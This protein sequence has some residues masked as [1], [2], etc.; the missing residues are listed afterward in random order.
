VEGACPTPSGIVVSGLSGSTANM[1][2]VRNSTGTEASA[3]SHHIAHTPPRT[4]GR[5]P[6]PVRSFP[7]TR[8]PPRYRTRCAMFTA[9]SSNFGFMGGG[10]SNEAVLIVPRYEVRV[11]VPHPNHTATKPLRFPKSRASVVA[12]IFSR[13]WWWTRQVGPVRRPHTW[14]G[15]EEAGS[16]QEEGSSARGPLGPSQGGFS[17][18]AFIL[19]FLFLILF[20]ALFLLYILNL[21]FEF[22]SCGEFVLKFVCFEHDIMG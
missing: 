2:P 3:R 13:C 7:A 8:S 20:P 9:P 21:E 18:S 16:A 22:K 12:A 14:R 19:F 1:N 10:S 15:R 11:G 6:P 17:P 5:G 4:C